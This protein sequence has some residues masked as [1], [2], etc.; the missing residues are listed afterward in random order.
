MKGIYRFHWDCGRAGDISSIFVAEDEDVN[1][2]IG[3]K[4]YFG[5][6]LGKHSE[7]YGTVAD[8]EITL[9][10]SEP[11]DVEMFERLHLSTGLNP[12]NF[13]DEEDDDEQYED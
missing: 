8:D 7:V 3:K 2:V 6:V 11:A 12:L 5:E 1:A 4:V 13:L 10:S 9:V